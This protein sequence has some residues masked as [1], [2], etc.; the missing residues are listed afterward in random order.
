MADWNKQLTK[1]PREQFVDTFP[2]LFCACQQLQFRRLVFHDRLKSL[3]QK[4][5]STLNGDNFHW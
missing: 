5:N 2:E 1:K 3:A 4:A